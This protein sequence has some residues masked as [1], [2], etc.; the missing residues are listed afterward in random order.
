MTETLKK[1]YAL[2]QRPRGI[3][4]NF[5]ETEVGGDWNTPVAAYENKNIQSLM[6]HTASCYFAWL[7]YFCM[8]QPY[9]SIKDKD[10]GTFDDLRMLYKK[11]DETVATFL[12]SFDGKMETPITALHWDE[13]VLTFTPLQLFT[14]VITHEFH[15]KGQIVMMSRILGYVPP[16]TDI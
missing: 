6:E 2:L 1:Q 10:F 8:R 5:I 13:E 4:F 12:Q 11:V 14:H 7:A 15:H 3:L 9:G 16:E